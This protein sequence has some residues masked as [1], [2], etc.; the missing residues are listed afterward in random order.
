MPVTSLVKQDSCPALAWRLDMRSAPAS[1]T[2]GLEATQQ[3]GPA[4]K[5][6]GTIDSQ[7]GQGVGQGLFDREF[8][9]Q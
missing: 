2:F 9:P 8:E 7:R 3:D 6:G 5:P 1:D 4:G